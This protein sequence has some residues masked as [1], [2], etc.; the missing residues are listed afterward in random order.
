MVATSRPR[1]HSGSDRPRAGR[2]ATVAYA[3]LAALGVLV[4]AYSLHAVFDP[5]GAGAVDEPLPSL[6]AHPWSFRVHALFGA[7]ALL[8]GL[9]QFLP[10]PTVRR[11]R[12]H[13]ILGRVYA[14]AVVVSAS[15]GLVLATG[16][17]VGL[18]DRLGF[19]TLG[20]LWIV[21]T[22][23]GVH[24]AIAGRRAEHRRHMMRSFGLACAAITLR[25]QLLA[26]EL[27][28]LPFAEF[29][30]WVAW[31]CWLPNLLAAEWIA[32]HRDGRTCR[33]APGAFP[34]LLPPR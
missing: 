16:P 12:W 29:Y 26:L 15:G 20:V 18:G 10:A 5:P 13:R 22:I 7:V 2:G 4:A 33:S 24:G 23:A 17:G 31:S 1:S 27:L 9:P 21:S 6:A 25:L 32:R 8:A 14:L 19:A 28:S 3:L 34:A 11:A 30:P